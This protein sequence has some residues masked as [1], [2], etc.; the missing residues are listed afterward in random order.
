MGAVVVGDPVAEG[1]AS[2]RRRNPLGG[3]EQ[4]LDPDR[5]PAERARIA[6]A[7]ASASARARSAHTRTNAFRTG[8]MR[9]IARSDASTSS[10]A[11]SSP[12][13]TSAA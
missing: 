7:Y 4:V 9:S 10:R 13:R 6:W 3:G 12:D 2:L 1:R 11:E 8:F 5:D